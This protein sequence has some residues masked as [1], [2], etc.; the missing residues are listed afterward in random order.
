MDEKYINVFENKRKIPFYTATIFTDKIR[1]YSTNKY[2]RN[3]L[4]NRTVLLA[5][6]QVKLFEKINDLL[7]KSYKLDKDT[8]VIISGDFAKYIRYAN[9]K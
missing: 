9:E 1:L 5:E 4:S 2:Q 3:E 8:K 7:I 6:N